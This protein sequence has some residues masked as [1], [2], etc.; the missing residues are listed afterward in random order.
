MLLIYVFVVV[1]VI[2]AAVVP[3]VVDRSS[4]NIVIIVIYIIDGTS[5]RQCLI[6]PSIYSRPSPISF[7]VNSYF[8]LSIV[9]SDIDSGFPIPQ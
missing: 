3:F 9:P 8:L 4:G 7:A 1:G 5:T 2:I 6:T